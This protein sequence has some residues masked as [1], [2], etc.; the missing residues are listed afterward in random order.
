MTEEQKPQYQVG[1]PL[2]ETLHKPHS[3][4][5]APL[6][7]DA[8]AFMEHT[9]SSERAWGPRYLVRLLRRMTGRVDN[10]THSLIPYGNGADDSTPDAMA[11]PLIMRGLLLMFLLFG[12]IGGW[13]SFV[14]M[15][16]GAVAPGPV[17][18][19]SNSREVQ[20]LEGG[21]IERILVREGDRVQKGDVLVKMDATTAEARNEQLRNQWLNAKA[22]EARLLAERDELITITFPEE[23]LE[24]EGKDEKITKSLDAQRRLFNTRRDNMQGELD[25]L[26]QKVRQSEEEIVGLKR[27]ISS[28]SRQISLLNDEISVVDALVK[29]GNATRP[30][31]L[32]LQRQSAQIEGQRGQSQALV[33]RAEQTINEARIAMLNRGTEFLNSVVAELKETQ[34]E[35]GTLAE[36]MRA[37]ADIVRRIEVT[38]P[39]SGQ[40]TGLQVFTETGVIQPG[41]VLM[42]I[43]P[44]DEALVVEARI[45]PNDI[46]IVRPGLESHVRITV[47]DTRQIKPL[48]GEVVVVSADRFDDQQT[49]EAYYQ[50]RINIPAEEIQDKLGDFELTAGMPTEVLIVTGSRTMLSYLT[51]PIRDSFGRAFR[52]E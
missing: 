17:V 33:S 45:N 25:V 21:I 35:I 4:T 15:D 11:A 29:K 6:R 38:A 44:L 20:H 28:A 52:Q 14:P 47:V 30:R 40:V 12:V 19:D 13:A 5:D 9:P 26:N 36:Q 24:L 42:A 10:A 50:A 7:A 49:G 31:L 23:L 27:Q 37:S 41:Q 1:A 48:K 16:T 3:E 2:S 8:D 22:T 39:I 18:V 34:Q 32:A 51:R 46:D 43:V